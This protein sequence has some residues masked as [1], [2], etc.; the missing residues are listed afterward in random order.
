MS[1]LPT[2]IL[3]KNILTALRRSANHI[4]ASPLLLEVAQSR[5]GGGVSAGCKPA[6][7]GLSEEEAERRLEQYGPNVVTQEQRHPAAASSWAGPAS[8][9]W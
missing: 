2:F 3:P 6:R 9:R 4:A 8:I 1:L 7:A 5:R